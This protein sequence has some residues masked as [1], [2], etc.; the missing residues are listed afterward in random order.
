M[1]NF[2]LDQVEEEEI[3]ARKDKSHLWKRK[4]YEALHSVENEVFPPWGSNYN[5]TDK[6]WAD[7]GYWKNLE[8]N[9]PPVELRVDAAIPKEIKSTPPPYD[10]LPY[11]T[12][13]PTEMKIT[14]PEFPLIKI[15]DI[16]VPAPDIKFPQV[17]F[18]CTALKGEVIRPLG[19]GEKE[20]Y[21][22]S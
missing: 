16:E 1:S 11:D 22:N 19:I 3:F 17:T 7:H 10:K 12:P 6:D 4:A 2:W 21:A 13:F 14:V 15:P 20:E 5:S 18:G 9:G 8:Y